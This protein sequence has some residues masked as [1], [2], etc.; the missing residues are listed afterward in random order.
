MNKKKRDSMSKHLCYLLRHNPVNLSIDKYGY[1]NVI[2][3]CDKVN[4]T[5]DDLKLIVEEDTKGR[6][7]FKN[8]LIK[9]CQ[10]HSFKVELETQE[11]TPPDILYH[12][13]SDNSLQLILKDGIKPMQRNLVHL[14]TDESIA[15][16]VGKRHGNPII[17]V[18]DAKRMFVDGY[19]FFCS[20]NG[21]YLTDYV[22]MS[23][24]EAHSELLS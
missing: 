18:I 12:G 21:V 7:L 10:G 13:T 3:L 23:Y 11:V 6:Y 20:E 22:P 16:H 14:S 1:V 24:I 17:L 5:L 8:D 15:Y 2:E 19:T 4:V 9:C